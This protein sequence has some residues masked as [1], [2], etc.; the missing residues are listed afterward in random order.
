MLFMGIISIVMIR[1]I[2]ATKKAYKDVDG[3]RTL[4]GI[5]YLIKDTD[6]E[7]MMY[8]LSSTCFSE[9]IT[10]KTFERT[11]ENEGL[12]T[13]GGVR[14]DIGRRGDSDFGAT[15]HVKMFQK[16]D[17][18][19]LKLHFVENRRAFWKS[20]TYKIP[21]FVLQ[22]AYHRFFKEQFD[23]KVLV[24]KPSKG[25]ILENEYVWNT[26]MAICMLSMAAVILLVCI[27]NYIVR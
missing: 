12:L 5:Q 25:V 9:I 16:E 2:L 3:V 7:Y 19:V 10:G 15:F 8:K 27:V 20:M 24:K 17:G 13:F 21:E 26:V 6:I 23:V 4:E 22:Q 14:Y 18:V 1:L 11:G